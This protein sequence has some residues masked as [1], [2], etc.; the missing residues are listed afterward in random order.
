ML[1]MSFVERGLQVIIHRDA[2]WDRQMGELNVLSSEELKTVLKKSNIAGW[3][4]D[5]GKYVLLFGTY[6]LVDKIPPDIDCIVLPLVVGGAA[7]G[8][9][10]EVYYGMRC[11]VTKKI[12]YERGVLKRPSII[13]GELK[14]QLRGLLRK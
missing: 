1:H 9:S 11:R 5:G 4:G 10:A 6:A 12:L 14:E 8:L 2:E 13:L 7:V 3:A